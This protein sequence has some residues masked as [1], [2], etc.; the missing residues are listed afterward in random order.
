MMYGT[1]TTAERWELRGQSDYTFSE[2]AY[3]YGHAG[4]RRIDL[5]NQVS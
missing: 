5:R 2:R 4:H 3:W 1:V